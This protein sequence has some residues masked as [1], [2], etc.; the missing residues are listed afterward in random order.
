MPTCPNGHQSGADD[1]CE[2]CGHRMAGPGAPRTA[3]GGAVPPPPRPGYGHPAA[4]GGPHPTAQAELCPQCRTPR[5]AMA[6][7]CEECRYNFLT[8]R[9]TSYTPIA[10][11]PQAPSPGLN[12]P[13]GFTRPPGPQVPLA[14]DRKSVV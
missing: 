7:F 10:P 4:G 5:E 9:A 13:P 3:E 8:Q 6:P 2:V 11:A 14:P 1:W 12:L